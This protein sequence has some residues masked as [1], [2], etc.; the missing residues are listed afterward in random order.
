M[1]TPEFDELASMMDGKTD[2]SKLRKLC[3]ILEYFFTS[4]QTKATS[5]VIIFTQYRESAKEIKDFVEADFLSKNMP[6]IVKAEL[7]LGQGG[8]VSQ[9]IQK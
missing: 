8:G 9:K 3:E 5:K 4:P 7:F 2:H 6:G 1:E